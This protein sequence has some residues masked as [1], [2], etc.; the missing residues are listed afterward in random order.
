MGNI[1]E[2]VS[3]ASVISVHPHVCGEHVSDF[4]TYYDNGGSS[5]RVWGT[6]GIKQESLRQ[7]RFI[8][9]CVGNISKHSHPSSWP[10]VHPHVCGEHAAGVVP[11]YGHVGS[12]PRV[13]GTSCHVPWDHQSTR[14][15]PTCVGNIWIS[16]FRSK[17]SAV[18]PHVC[19]EH[20]DDF[21]LL[22]FGVGSSPRVWGTFV[23]ICH[24]YLHNRF[25]PTCVG[26]M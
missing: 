17:K 14:F 9:T 12:S 15:I 26:N 21:Q 8:P 13:W 11:S 16:S 20:Q 23:L 25:I 10:S 7:I 22:V 1:T 3:S 2:T 6:S 4:K 24:Y 19:G 18:H 5:P